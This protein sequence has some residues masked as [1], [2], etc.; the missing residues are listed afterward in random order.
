[1]KG[2]SCPEGRDCACVRAGW[3]LF[4]RSE[5]GNLGIF[6]AYGWLFCLLLPEECK[7]G[8]AAALA[9]CSSRSV[10]RRQHVRTHLITDMCVYTVCIKWCLNKWWCSDMHV[11][12]KKKDVHMWVTS[13]NF[14]YVQYD[15]V[16][17]LQQKAI[18][19]HAR[20]SLL[21][22]CLCMCEKFLAWAVGPVL[23]CIC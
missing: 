7:E 16:S 22:L 10:P 19:I 11:W 5:I 4:V 18:I 13:V 20:K 8:Q 23:F 9:I 3:M 6:L 2:R 14:V 17:L 15:Q 21:H 12:G 1:M